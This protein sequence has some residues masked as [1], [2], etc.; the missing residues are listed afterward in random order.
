MS[1]R[2]TSSRDITKN[3]TDADDRLIGGR[4]NDKLYGGAGDDQLAGGSG[5]DEL[6][7]GSGNDY[8]VGGSGDDILYGGEGADT[9][10][11]GTGNDTAYF[12]VGENNGTGDNY[13]GGTG[14]DTLII[15]VGAAQLTDPNIVSDLRLLLDFISNNSDS[16]ASN[17]PSLQLQH[18]NLTVSNW[19]SIQLVDEQGNPIELPTE[20][21][22]P[23]DISLSS[24]NVD[25]NTSTSSFLK[26]YRCISPVAR[27]EINLLARQRAGEMNDHPSLSVCVA[28]WIH[29]T[30]YLLPS[31]CLLL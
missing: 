29:C 28:K 14:N 20:N 17:G 4:G 16:S 19:E 10:K 30:A 3:G 8:L 15:S 25:E 22:A 9:I 6:H 13:D 24:S 5:N 21:N 23:T 2:R 18:L 31:H 27:Y 12:T 26:L 7:G 1:R 11:A